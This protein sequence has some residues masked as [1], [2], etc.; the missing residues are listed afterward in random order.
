MDKYFIEFMIIGSMKND[1]RSIVY[2]VRKE[3]N[4]EGSRPIPHIS[5]VYDPT[6]KN[7][8]RD[9]RKLIGDFNSICSKYPLMEFQFWGFDSFTDNGAAII[10]IIPP[11]RMIDLRW[12]LICRL[13]EYCVLHPKYDATKNY[14]IPH[15][16]V[17]LKLSP[18]KLGD[19]MGHLDSFEQPRKHYYMARATLLK[20]GKILREYDFVLR[21]SLAR[22]EAL[23]KR[24]E[25]RTLA[26]IRE[27]IDQKI[28]TGSL[29]HT[30][31]TGRYPLRQ[32]RGVPARPRRIAHIERN[33]AHA[34]R[35]AV[36]KF[37]QFIFTI[38]WLACL[39]LAVITFYLPGMFGLVPWVGILIFI[40]WALVFFFVARGFRK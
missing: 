36:R 14:Y 35:V 39:V 26:G 13:R 27:T 12:D 2:D 37:L 6:P 19:V 20:N 11:Q 21:R 25:A 1:I 40:C 15:V 18:E 31:R 8:R 5:I 23:N 7:A 16:A 38:L 17:V 9:E 28:Q 3:L 30:I 29:H 32:I 4:L 10:K 24:I 22:I 33:H 34:S